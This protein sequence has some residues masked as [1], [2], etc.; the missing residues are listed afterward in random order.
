L[1]ALSLSVL[2]FFALFAPII[3]SFAERPAAPFL[4]PFFEFDPPAAALL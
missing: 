4:V 1:K 3:F 2:P